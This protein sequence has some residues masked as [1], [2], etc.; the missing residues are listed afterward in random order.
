MLINEARFTPLTIDIKN[1][2]KRLINTFYKEN[3]EKRGKLSNLTLDQSKQ[4]VK[5]MLHQSKNQEIHIGNINL[6]KSLNR[7]IPIFIKETGSGGTY[8]QESDEYNEHIVIGF[9]TIFTN[10]DYILST[11]AHEVIHAIQQYRKMSS[12]YSNVSDK[13]ETSNSL[14]KEE[15]FLYYTEPTEFEA[16]A[17]ELAYNIIRFYERKKVDK[18]KVL[19]LL[20]N[21]LKFPK[22]KMHKFFNSFYIRYLMQLPD[23]EQDLLNGYLREMF[24][25]KLEFLK[26]I[27]EPPNNNLENIKRSNRYWRQFKQ[28]LFNLTQSLKRRFS[29]SKAGIAA[30]NRPAPSSAA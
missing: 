4:N 30:A 20:D 22:Q 13:I 15:D 18:E 10:L 2:I 9:N 23:K 28:K 14:T 5:K 8:Y 3:V 21:V 16:Q 26:V 6:G 25:R 27:A 19:F 12:R 1:Q 17:S 29:K 11:L 7:E 24:F